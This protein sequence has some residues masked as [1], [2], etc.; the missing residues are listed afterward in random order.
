MNGQL[1]TEARGSRSK[2]HTPEQAATLSV[3]KG[4]RFLAAKVNVPEGNSADHHMYARWATIVDGWAAQGLVDHSA[5]S[6][7][8]DAI[9][10]V[11]MMASKR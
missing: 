2:K 11:L 6:Q 4:L 9:E 7:F 3:A 5:R 1:L 8:S 10:F